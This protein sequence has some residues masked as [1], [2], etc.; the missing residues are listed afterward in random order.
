MMMNEIFGDYKKSIVK[1]T[2]KVRLF[3]K[4]WKNTATKDKVATL[5]K[6]I[7]KFI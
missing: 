1:K 3:K 2:K 5:Y 7:E 4:K 6:Y